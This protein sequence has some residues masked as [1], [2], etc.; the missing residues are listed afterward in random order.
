M[1]KKVSVIM[2]VHNAENTVIKA[3]NSVIKM[4]RAIHQKKYVNKKQQRM[5]E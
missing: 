5:K 2:P 1:E 3:I 4:V